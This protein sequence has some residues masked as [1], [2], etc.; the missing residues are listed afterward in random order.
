MIG[1]NGGF[2]SRPTTPIKQPDK[3]EIH[4]FEQ[5]INVAREGADG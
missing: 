3:L 2:A 5:V 1:D 4:D